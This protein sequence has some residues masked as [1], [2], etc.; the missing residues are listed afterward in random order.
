MTD[1]VSRCVRQGDSGETWRRELV[2]QDG[3]NPDLLG[4]TVWFRARSIDRGRLEIHQRA[5]IVDSE[6]GV[7]EYT[8]TGADTAKP[9]FF[10]VLWRVQWP[11]SVG[12]ETFPVIDYDRLE[13]TPAIA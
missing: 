6:N 7:V 13:I 3:S 2:L 8:L 10:D 1:G 4:T 9:G 5:T 12:R 11:G